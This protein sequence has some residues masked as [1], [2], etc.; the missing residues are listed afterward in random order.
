MKAQDPEYMMKPNP[1]L[2]NNTQSHY[3]KMLPVNMNP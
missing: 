1:V 3:P 2:P